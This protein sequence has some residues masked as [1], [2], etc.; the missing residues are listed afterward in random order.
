MDIE[1]DI[2]VLY[3]GVISRAKGYY[4]LLERFGPARLTL[5]GLNMLDEPVVGRYLGLVPYHELPLL[6]NRARVF[7]HLPEWDE[8]MGRTVVEARLCGCQVVLNERV[9][10]ASYPE[11][12]WSD[13]DVVRRHPVRFWE[14]VEAA[15][16]CL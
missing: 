11:A 14:D 16:E 4:N 2:D 10:V 15:V 13:P 3:V 5:A 9:G 8:P 1:R 7:A 6:Y 12:E